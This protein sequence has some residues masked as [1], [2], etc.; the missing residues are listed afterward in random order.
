LTSNITSTE[1]GLGSE[2]SIA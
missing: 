1:A 2:H